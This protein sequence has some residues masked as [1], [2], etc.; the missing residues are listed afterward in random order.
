MPQVNFFLELFKRIGLYINR[1]EKRQKF[2]L[3]F[4]ILTLL[5]SL[6]FNKLLKP[7]MLKLRHL[8]L[9]YSQLEKQVLNLKMQIPSL[10]KERLLL[11][12]A[13]KRN[14]QLQ[15]ELTGLEKE[16]SGSYSITKLLGELA[17]QAGDYNID[18]LYIKLKSISKPEMDEEYARLDI[19]MQFNASYYDFRDYLMRLEGLSVFLNISD[20]VIEEIKDKGFVGETTVTLLLSTLL[21]K[22]APALVSGQPLFVKENVQKKEGGFLERIPF[23]PD[24]SWIKKYFKSTKYTLSGITFADSNSTAIINN[25]L[26]RVGDVLD[27]KWVIKKILPNMVIISKGR[28]TETLVLE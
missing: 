3:S 14:K 17:R 19:E 2:L 21:S 25:E 9:E 10:D 12:D 20:I 28:Q 1:L 8:K 24:S 22:D 6:Y 7:Q 11:Q 18:F 26:Y 23:L 16:V 5:F 15:E 4:L 13:Q 27:G